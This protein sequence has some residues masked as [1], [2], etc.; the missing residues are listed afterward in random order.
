MSLLLR[1]G[2][3]GVTP[4]Q[5]P[6]DAREVPVN[7]KPSTTYAKG[8]VLG[9]VTATPGQYAPYN[10]GASDG[11]QVAKLI[12][13]FACKTD[14]AGNVWLGDTVS[15]SESG[16]PFGKYAPAWRCG[17]FQC[18]DLAGLDAAAVADLGRLLSGDVSTGILI[19]YG[20]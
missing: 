1:F 14:S 15:L 16:L 12:L 11:T 20:E 8:Q 4:Y 18:A 3:N 19:V 13:Q 10:D 6:D 17:I 2:N 7:L 9:P 5:N